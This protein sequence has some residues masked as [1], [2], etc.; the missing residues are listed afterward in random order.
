MTVR[1]PLRALLSILYTAAVLGGAFGISYAVFEWRDED[2][3][4][5][6]IDR[7]IE[8]LDLRID[9]LSSQVSG[10]SASI[11]LYSDSGACHRSII[12]LM[13]VTIQAQSGQISGGALESR[14]SEVFDVLDSQC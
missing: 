6:S 12:E 2:A 7:Q 9:S 1:I 11:G 14:V 5:E 10:V 3:G 4:S 8:R 13:T